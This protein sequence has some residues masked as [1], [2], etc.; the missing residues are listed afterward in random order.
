M[1]SS[2]K[3]PSLSLQRIAEKLEKANFLLPPFR[4]SFLCKRG[5]KICHQ[6]LSWRSPGK[7]EDKK[8]SYFSAR[9][10]RNS[11]WV[12]WV[13]FLQ[14]CPILFLKWNPAGDDS[15]GGFKV[16]KR[17]G[18]TYKTSLTLVPPYTS[19]YL[20]RVFSSVDHARPTEYRSNDC[21][22]GR[23]ICHAQCSVVRNRWGFDM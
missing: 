7:S 20:A 8:S 17:N 12:R 2:Y 18:T 11:G 14:T 1:I 23:F 4:L 21:I 15:E 3:K 10:F 9:H 22:H 13:P 16:W 19:C 5:K 6:T